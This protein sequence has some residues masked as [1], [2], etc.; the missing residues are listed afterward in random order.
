VVVAIHKDGKDAGD[1]AC[2]LLAGT[3]SLKQF[4]QIAEDARRIAARHGRLSGGQRDFARR[5]GESRHRIDNKQNRFPSV[6][7]IFGDAHR[8]LWGE[9][10]H[11]RAFV[12]GCDD[13]D[14]AGAIHGHCVVEEFAHFAP[15]LADK[16]HHDGVEFNGGGE[17]RQ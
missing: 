2:S 17:H 11:G 3:R 9:A 5:V 14:R 12:S 16:R 15:A 7:E 10:T 1:R 4:R 13:S 6:A 8:R